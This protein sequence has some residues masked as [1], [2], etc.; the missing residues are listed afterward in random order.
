MIGLPNYGVDPAPE[1]KTDSSPRKSKANRFWETLGSERMK[2]ILC[3]SEYNPY[4]E[5]PLPERP[6]IAVLP[7]TNIN[8]DPAQDYIGDG[9]LIKLSQAC[10][11]I[12]QTLLWA[13]R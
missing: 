11:G 13:F 12:L 2:E 6:S 7:F 3:V 10:S 1:N 5:Y 9:I 4:D 8:G